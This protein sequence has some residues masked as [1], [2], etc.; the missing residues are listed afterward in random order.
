MGWQFE[1]YQTSAKGWRWKMRDPKGA[2]I[3]ISD[4][5]YPTFEAARKEISNIKSI[6]SGVHSMKI[7]DMDSKAEVA[8]RGGG[9]AVKK[10]VQ[11]K[12][13][14]TNAEKS[15]KEDKKKTSTSK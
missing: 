10:T 3:C 9:R 8:K 11:P 2:L 14:E 13:K 6:I 4:K 7:V 15:A 12:D 5:S 1:I